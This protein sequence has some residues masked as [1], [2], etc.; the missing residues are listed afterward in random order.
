M[1]RHGRSVVLESVVFSTDDAGTSMSSQLVSST[2]SV[3]VFD[4]SD[5]EVVSSPSLF[6]TVVGRTYRCVPCT[7]GVGVQVWGSPSSSVS[8]R[9]DVVVVVVEPG[10][11]RLAG[12]DA[13]GHRFFSTALLVD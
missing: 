12:F 4:G 13:D 2:V 7:H 5:V 11:R 10:G 8:G 3:P 9:Y 6:V 1:C